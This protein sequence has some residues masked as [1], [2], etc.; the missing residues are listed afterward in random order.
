[1][2]REIL[3]RLAEAHD[4]GR[5]CALVTVAETR[6]SVPRA[7]GA[8]M[9]VYRDGECFGTIGGGKFEALVVA[10]SRAALDSGEP[11]LKHYPLHEAAAESFGAICGGEVTV[12]IEPQLQRQRL[13]IVGAG[14]C[15]RA[16]AR[17]AGECGFHVTVID[18]RAELLADF[19]QAHRMIS[20][21]KWP[22]FLRQHD[23]RSGDA[24]VVVSRNYLLDLEA[25]AVAIGFPAIGYVGMIGS[26]RKVQRV[27]AELT[28]RDPAN[29]QRLE[30]V[31]APIGLDIGADAPAEIAVAVIA[32]I[33]QVLRAG[34][35]GHLRA[36]RASGD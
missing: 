27:F 9:L 32:E 7:A 1:M 26:R 22:D 20:G 36:R 31:F 3:S 6:G 34:R 35:G 2:N 4:A 11:L 15:A 29:A 17:L 25:L 24:L 14:H 10:A 28:A 12:L 5:P 30:R 13:V 21:D 18:D 19:P 8:K 33:L 16:L 23:W